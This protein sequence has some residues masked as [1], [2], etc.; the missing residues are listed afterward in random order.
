LIAE[1]AFLFDAFSEIL[2]D[3]S[4]IFVV[5]ESEAGS[6]LCQ[7]GR[8]SMAFGS[9]G[10]NLGDVSTE[11]SESD[12]S[13]S[14]ELSSIFGEQM[15]LFEETCEVSSDS[16]ERSGVFEFNIGVSDSFPVGEERSSWCGWCRWGRGLED[17]NCW[18]RISQRSLVSLR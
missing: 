5:E 12:E 8:E 6:L 14:D 15:I 17:S 7:V 11:E 18:L 1:E 10:V 9:V 16:G 13:A 3:K 2:S 4:N